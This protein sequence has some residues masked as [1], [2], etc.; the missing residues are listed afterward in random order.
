MSTLQLSDEVEVLR[1]AMMGPPNS[2]PSSHM[3]ATTANDFK[4][5]NP[6]AEAIA[7]MFITSRKGDLVSAAERLHNLVSL[8]KYYQLSFNLTS[9]IRQGIALRVIQPTC[10]EDSDGHPVIVVC[11]RNINWSV[12][13]VPQM[14]KTWFYIIWY[15]LRRF[16]NAQ[17]HGVKLVVA[18]AEI[19]PRMLRLPFQYFV[20][21]AVQRCLPVR[22]ANVFIADQP[23]FFGTIF[24][25]IKF[26]MSVKLRERVVSVYDQHNKITVPLE[27][28][29]LELGG[30]FTFDESFLLTDCNF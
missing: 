9:D 27:V 2:S 3:D 29:P 21:H 19:S 22:I 16:P 26:A 25:V 7:Q 17:V 30:S 10:L 6:N 11:P 18:A 28:L 13:T 15:V 20:L 4:C 23:W 5:L 14:Q 12:V 24:G 8:V 1:L